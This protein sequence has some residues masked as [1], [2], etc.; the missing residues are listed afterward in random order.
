[1]RQLG[2]YARDKKN[3]LFQFE[4]GTDDSFKILVEGKFKLAEPDDYQILEIGYYTAE[5]SKDRPRF[6]EG[7]IVKLDP[8]FRELD[9]FQLKIRYVIKKVNEG[10]TYNI[11]SLDDFEYSDV[12]ENL[13]TEE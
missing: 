3:N 1:M 2:Y 13:L 12:A 5:D 4:W 8:N 6:K 11:L 9:S 7:Q 10:G